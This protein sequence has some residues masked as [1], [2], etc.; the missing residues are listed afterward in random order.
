MHPLKFCWCARKP[1]QLRRIQA[2]CS[3]RAGATPSS[4]PNQIVEQCQRVGEGEKEP[5]PPPLLVPCHE[6]GEQP[7]RQNQEAGAQGY[8]R[9][10]IG[11]QGKPW[12]RHGSKMP[13]MD[14]G[15]KGTSLTSHG[16][17]SERLPCGCMPLISALTLPLVDA[18]VRA[19]VG[20]FQT[21][22]TTH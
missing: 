17:M 18:M 22:N 14:R 3:K 15:G 16:V 21:S 12:S 6:N 20:V 19:F 13:L 2:G 4:P 5:E 1:P 9:Q 10:A 11:E 8:P 7:T